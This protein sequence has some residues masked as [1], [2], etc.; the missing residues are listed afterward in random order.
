MDAKLTL[1]LYLVLLWL[2]VTKVSLILA[3]EKTGGR[4]GL[5]LWQFLV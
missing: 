5:W 2:E 4:S 3:A 1:I